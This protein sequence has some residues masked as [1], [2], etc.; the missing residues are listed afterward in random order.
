MS[1]QPGN[2]ESELQRNSRNV[3]RNRQKMSS[4][5]M[6]QCSSTNLLSKTAHRGVFTRVV[7]LLSVAALCTATVLSP[8]T[9]SNVSAQE[10]SRNYVR[11]TPE[12]A[13]APKMINLG[14]NKSLVVDLPADA[15]DVLVANPTVADAVMRT[16][17]RI[18]LFGK[19]IGQTN[20][21]VFDGSGKQIA[22]M[23]INIERDITGLEATFERLIPNSEIRAEMI[24]DNIVLT[25][26]VSTPLDATKA[27]QLAQIFIDGGE[28]A[29]NNNQGGGLAALFGDEEE[30]NIVNLLKI[31]GHDQV[32]LKVSI[33]EVQRLVTKQ[34]GLNTGISNP[35]ASG[36]DG[37]GFAVTG[38]GSFTQS[39]AGA[40]NRGTLNLEYGQNSLQ[41]Q[42]R[43]MES[44]GVVRTLAEPNLT[45]VSGEEA[46]FR[47]GG[48][49]QIPSNVSETDP[50][51][52]STEPGLRVQ[53][54]ELPYGVYLKFTPTVLSEGRISLR[55]N[56]EVQEPSATGSGSF[57][58]RGNV[59]GTRTRKAATTVEIPS[60][61][62]MA[63][64]GLVQDDV[65]QVISGLP[66][67]K[68]IPIFGGLFR[69]RE[70][71][72]NET[73]VVVIV[74]PYLVRPT[75]RK[76]LAQPDENFHP[77]SEGAG[78][79]LGRLNRVYGTKQ[80]NLPK[81]RYTGSIGF[82]LK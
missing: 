82:I 70:Y 75:A 11:I 18:Y 21:F 29:Q 1:I 19:Q 25:G 60:G 63:I 48:Q 4:N 80:G 61:G 22:A 7:G 15:N 37:F 57:I 27:M 17:R 13:N 64:A 50:P 78:V 46:E 33:V 55:L 68:N 2:T 71:Q 53:Y 39:I 38:G 40:A 58:E 20:I 56:T 65:R 30:S 28:Q 73:E 32:M 31:A 79:F 12:N 35:F 26:T 45:A 66:G 8:T 51:D 42:L 59:R 36:A 5:V 77:A 81:G 10:N 62:S 41:S 3:Q 44:A 72:R 24:N 14:L 9:I 49:W 6:T 74:T 67:L 52:G 43:A 54:T 76:N 47:V 23:E 34:L 16:S 69:S